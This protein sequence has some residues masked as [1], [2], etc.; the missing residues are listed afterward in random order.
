MSWWCLGE[1]L[2]VLVDVLNPERIVVGGLA[3]RLGEHLL[4]P[5]RARM[6]EEALSASAKVCTLVAASLGESIGDVA[7][8]CVATGLE[9]PLP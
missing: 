7:A 4:R 8:L 6:E 9:A 2:A 1:A 3:L 5:A